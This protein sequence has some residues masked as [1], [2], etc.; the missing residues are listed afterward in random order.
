M[1]IL[2]YLVYDLGFLLFLIASSLFTI[3]IGLKT[4]SK[5]RK[6][7]FFNLSAIP[8]ALCLFEVF[9][10]L[11][12]QEV[13]PTYSGTYTENSLATGE[14]PL[15]GYGPQSDTIFTS[16]L[17][18]K[19]GDAIIFDASYNFK[20]GHRTIP[21][22]NDSSN[23]RIALLGGSHMFGEGLN[24]D[25][26]TGYFI[27]KFS[28]NQYNITNHAFNGYGTHQALI[29]LQNETEPSEIAIYYFI[30]DHIY[31]TAGNALWD[32]KGP[33]FEVESNKLNHKGSFENNKTAKPNYLTKRLEIIWRNSQ[34]FKAF[35]EGKYDTKDI[36]RVREIIKEINKYATANNTKFI[37][38][39]KEDSNP[40]IAKSLLKE[41]FVPL[42]EENIHVYFTNEI[43]KD[44]DK[45]AAT[46]FIEGDGHP[47]EQH[48]QKIG[49]F[50]HKTLVL[51]KEH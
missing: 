32:K 37:L 44:L 10:S 45:N 16:T 30:T 51:N 14:K 8:I 19:N 23:N 1:D 5:K 41:L 2:R 34:T 6:Y 48:N 4:N 12:H 33:L 26:T 35:F 13:Q 20:N 18:R 21:N 31:R 17:T 38:L 9:S 47:N 25:Q 46:Y 29:S 49:S 22:N 28:N 7:I 42:K 50:L 43:I 36:I 15:V 39:A 3:F 27:N 40:D 24:D 11:S